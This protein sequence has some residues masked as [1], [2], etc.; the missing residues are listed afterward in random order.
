[1]GDKSPKN[2]TKVK[3]QK[4]EGKSAKSASGQQVVPGEPKRT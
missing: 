4:A 3:K 2:A 1:M